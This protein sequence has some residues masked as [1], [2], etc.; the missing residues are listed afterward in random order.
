MGK[1]THS[2]SVWVMQKVKSEKETRGNWYACYYKAEANMRQTKWL[3]QAYIRWPGSCA[4][5]SHGTDYMVSKIKN[6]IKLTSSITLPK[7]SGN[8]MGEN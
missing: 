4:G 5:S 8:E 1:K 6:K 2:A 7:P 3:K